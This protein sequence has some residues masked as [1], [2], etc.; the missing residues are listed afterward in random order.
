MKLT[1]FPPSAQHAGQRIALGFGR[2]TAADR[3]SPGFLICGAQRCGTTSMYRALR[4]HPAILKPLLHKGIHYFD[5]GYQN[6]PSWY[7]AHFPLRAH[8]RLIAR[9]QRVEPLTF[10]SS[11][12]YLFHPL[13]ASRIARDLPDVRIIVLLRDPVER[14]YSA[15]THERAR[16]FE[17]EEFETALALED[18]RLS[19]EEDRIVADPGNY[20]YSHQHHAYLR[21]GRYLEQLR[22]I[23]NV[24]G[25]DRLHVVDSDD[26]FGDPLPTWREVIRFLQLPDPAMPVFDQ[27]N[28][29]PRSPM[30]RSLRT[31]LRDQFQPYDEALAR[32][33]GHEPSWRR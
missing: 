25:R 22:R 27:H 24:I 7:R 5:T 6:G 31:Q 26:F 33:W 12:Y 19:G 32:W 10:E 2:L 30:P 3:M 23:E 15:Y 20:S 14:A 16:G 28:A 1:D 4:Q 21:R 29:R 9:R 11:P 18:S 17:T 13:A 8:A